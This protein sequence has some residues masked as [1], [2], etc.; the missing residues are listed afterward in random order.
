MKMKAYGLLFPRYSLASPKHKQTNIRAGS[1][2][3]RSV[4]LIRSYLLRSGWDN[5]M[6]DLQRL[7][8]EVQTTFKLSGFTI[9]S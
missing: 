3:L 2:R 9:R 6:A 7:K 8:K 1:P 5:R 4:P